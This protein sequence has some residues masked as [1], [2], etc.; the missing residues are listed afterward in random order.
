LGMS[1][2]I[3]DYDAFQIQA[4][5]REIDKLERSDLLAPYKAQ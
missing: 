5:I 2:D 4:V 3:T 1:G